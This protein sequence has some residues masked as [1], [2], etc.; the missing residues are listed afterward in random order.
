VVFLLAK[1]LVGKKAGARRFISASNR[2]LF[3]L[4]N[5]SNVAERARIATVVVAVPQIK[6]VKATE[7]SIGK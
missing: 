2:V 5:L 3:S 1:L 4:D 6:T 7:E